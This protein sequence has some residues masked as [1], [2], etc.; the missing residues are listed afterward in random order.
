MHQIQFRLGLRPDFAGE[1]TAL[2]QTSYL[3]LRGLRLRGAEGKRGS[4]G[5]GSPLLFSADLHPWLILCV[6]D[7]S[8][9]GKHKPNEYA[10]GQDN[11]A[12]NRQ[13]SELVYQDTDMGEEA[14]YEE[15]DIDEDTYEEI[16]QRYSSRP[17]GGAKGNTRRTSV[18]PPNTNNKAAR[19]WL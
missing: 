19:K 4:G 15:T 14:I 11:K 2:P 18:Y 17:T 3:D 8:D 16:S 13:T 10:D 6:D 5:E 1:H 7:N 9:D 12:T